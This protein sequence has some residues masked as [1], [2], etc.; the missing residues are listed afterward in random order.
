MIPGEHVSEAQ[1]LVEVDEV[2]A[3]TLLDPQVLLALARV[4]GQAA[5]RSPEES[6]TSPRGV[7]A[8]L[9]G[10]K[11]GASQRAAHGL[12]APA[13]RKGRRRRGVP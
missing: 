5:R 10:Q 6:S 7:A 11:P 4:R 8:D 3:V 2:G 13:A 12:A 1:L 9:L